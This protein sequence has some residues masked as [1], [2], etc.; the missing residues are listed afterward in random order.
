MDISSDIKSLKQKYSKKNISKKNILC[1]SKYFYIHKI[2]PKSAILLSSSGSTGSC[3]FI[4]ISFK[5]LKHNPQNYWSI[6]KIKIKMIK[7]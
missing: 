3:K 2:D 7:L 4:K 1:K 5:N 6:F